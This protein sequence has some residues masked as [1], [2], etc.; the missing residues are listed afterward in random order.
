MPKPSPPK[1]RPSPI[2]ARPENEPAGSPRPTLR[3]N[4]VIA[5][6][7]PGPRPSQ[8]IRIQLAGADANHLFQ[9]TDEDLAVAA[10]A[11]ARRLLDGFQRALQ[12][13]VGQGA[14]QLDL[15]QKIAHVFCAAV[16]FGVAFLASEA[17]D[18]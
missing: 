16:Q 15:G 18:L 10:L 14:V 8:R 4:H 9:R 17:L 6:V 13:V 11:G 5:T 3:K 12:Q 7:A 2:K 1:P